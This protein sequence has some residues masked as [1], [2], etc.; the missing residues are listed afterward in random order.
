[1]TDISRLNTPA[2]IEAYDFGRFRKIVDVGGSHGMLLAAILRRHPGPNGIVFDLRDAVEG[3]QRTIVA[4]GLTGRA[5]AVAGNFFECVPAGGDAYVLKQVIHDWDDAPAVAILRS[6]RQAIQPDGRLLVI[7]FVVP[8]AN[9][10]SPAKLLDLDMLA[11][12]GGLERTEVEYR[13]L[14][15]AAEFG[16][17][18][19][20]PTAGPQCV[21]E[22]VAVP[23]S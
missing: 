4:G 16:L 22:G 19:V 9:E 18:A 23:T 14:F 20:H 11:V 5:E 15:A 12:T 2:I 6:V 13:D 21:I 1:M 7:E 17:V 8:S 10:P 3:A